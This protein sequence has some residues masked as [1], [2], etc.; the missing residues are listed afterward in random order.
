MGK[1]SNQ[2]DL[3]F[4]SLCKHMPKRQRT[5]CRAPCSDNT[6]RVLRC[7]LTSG[8]S[9]VLN[10]QQC[11]VEACNVRKQLVTSR[12]M[13]QPPRLNAVCVTVP[14][15]VLM[16]FFRIMSYVVTARHRCKSK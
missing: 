8:G 10:V 1:Q 6:K 9:G 15:P 12:G 3:V 14:M 13:C 4:S 5:N 7:R 16:L 11:Y 2:V